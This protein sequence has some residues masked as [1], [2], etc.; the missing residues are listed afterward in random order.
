MMAAQ[1]RVPRRLM[2]KGSCK[3]EELR[4]TQLLNQMSH[5]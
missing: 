5:R 2:K 1:Q 4:L 3:V